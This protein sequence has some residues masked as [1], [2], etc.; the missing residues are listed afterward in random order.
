MAIIK[1][2]ALHKLL[3]EGWE[4]ER[5]AKTM[6][7]NDREELV[8]HAKAC[9]KDIDII[10]SNA[11]KALPR[12]AWTA[13]SMC[14]WTVLGVLGSWPLTPIFGVIVIG[15]AAIYNMKRVYKSVCDLIA[16]RHIP[17][18]ERTSEAIQKTLDINYEIQQELSSIRG[19]IGTVQGRPYAK[20]AILPQ[21]VKRL[22]S[23]TGQGWLLGR[24]SGYER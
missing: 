13:V 11:W 7:S 24:L 23:T 14:G 8:N 22:P 10:K 5:V 21:R 3:R 18:L 6:N 20:M 12:I 16:P 17:V 2:T 1:G 19:I 4:P 15:A 9:M